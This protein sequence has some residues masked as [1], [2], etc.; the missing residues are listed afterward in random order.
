MPA[1]NNFNIRPE[2]A[3]IRINVKNH[4]IVVAHNSVGRDINCKNLWQIEEFILQPAATMF[5]GIAG[6]IICATQKCP[7]D[8]ARYA[9]IIGCCFK[10][11]L[12]FSGLWHDGF[13][14][15]SND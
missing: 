13:L 11:D 10:L 2:V 7:A 5:V 12:L 8:A 4:M 14:H 6:N 1:L 9:V 15:G 3:A